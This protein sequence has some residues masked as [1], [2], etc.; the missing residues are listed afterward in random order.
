MYI[1]RKLDIARVLEHKSCFLLGPR[2]CG[3]SSLIRETLPDAYVFDLLSMDVFSRLARNSRYLEETCLETKR[4][5]VIDEIQ[6]MPSLLDE[7]HRLMETKGMTFLL[8]GSSARK[9]SRGGVNLLGGRARMRHLHP[10]SASELG[11][12][13]DLDKAL[14][15]GLLP[16]VWF[17]DNPAEDL[18]SYVSLYLEQEIAQEG[19]TRHLP[20]F[21]RFLEVAALSSGEQINYQSLAS[22][23][24]VP[25]STVQEYFGI[26]KDTLLV[27]EIPVWR[28]GRSRKT[29]E[30]S[31]FYLFDTGVARRL[32]GR[33]RLVQG[34]PEYGHAFESWILHELAAYADAFRLDMP[35]SYWRTRTGLEVDFVIGDDE[36][37]LEAKT[38]RD[39]TKNDLKGLRSIDGE[40]TFRHRI[41]VCQEPRERRVDG[42]EILPWP[43]F[44]SRLWSGVLF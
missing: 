7:V 26:L 34:T 10:F 1:P 25:R 24:R 8:T 21:S 13:F 3:K 39:A 12:A 43:L 6:K 23:A 35:I 32:Q 19:A 22:D 33:P 4:P 9:L 29:V 42:I 40:R 36:I 18:S 38:T 44:V 5:I 2:Q 30:T 41:L 20:A 11:S 27:R 37:A 15:D 17:S 31:K 14:N 16:P 28:K